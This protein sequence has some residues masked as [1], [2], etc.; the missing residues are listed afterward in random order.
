MQTAIWLDD[1]YPLKVNLSFDGRMG[2]PYGS[3]ECH[4]ELYRGRNENLKK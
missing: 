2:L 3:A 1:N 4:W